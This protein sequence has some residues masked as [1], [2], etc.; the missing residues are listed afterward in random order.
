MKKILIF[1]FLFML[2][3]VS[4]FAQKEDLFKFK[5][6]KYG[7]M[8]SNGVLIN[9][10]IKANVRIFGIKTVILI[11]SAFYYN[12]IKLL[13]GKTSVEADSSHADIGIYVDKPFAKGTI[14]LGRY[15]ICKCDIEI[16]PIQGCDIA[17]PMCCLR[18]KEED[19]SVVAVNILKRE[20]KVMGTNSYSN[21]P[22]YRCFDFAMPFMSAPI[23]SGPIQFFNRDMRSTGFEGVFELNAHTPNFLYLYM[24]RPRVRDFYYS[25]LKHFYMGNARYVV[26]NKIAAQGFHAFS[27]SF[28]K[29]NSSNCYV[30]IYGKGRPRSVDG[31][32]GSAFFK[33]HHVVFDFN[34]QKVY[35]K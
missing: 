1:G 29:I 23:I 25:N 20:I 28:G 19:S 21:N 6:D 27:C 14:K 34:A 2:L 9:D 31:T 15:T 17:L 24:Y 7:Q 12:N 33:Q 30:V 5:H 35:I 16:R 3:S 13:N 18:I 4:L 32:L 22:K 26:N 11:D 10:K 8:L